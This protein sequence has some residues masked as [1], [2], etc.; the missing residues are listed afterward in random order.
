LDRLWRT[1]PPE[2]VLRMIASTSSK[3]IPDYFQ[4]KKRKLYAL[5]SQNLDSRRPL[6]CKSLKRSAGPKSLIIIG[7]INHNRWANPLPCLAFDLGWRITCE[8]P[9]S[10]ACRLTFTCSDLGWAVGSPAFRSEP[11]YCRCGA[12]QKAGIWD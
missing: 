4:R 11:L 3:T 5:Q 6:C 10:L 12:G 7:T 8:I 9:I 1:P 2:L